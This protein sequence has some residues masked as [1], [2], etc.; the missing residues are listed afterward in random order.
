MDGVRCTLVC[1]K[2]PALITL[3]DAVVEDFIVKV[4]TGRSRS[5]G[6]ALAAGA[7]GAPAGLG[8]RT[9]RQV[10]ARWRVLWS[11]WSGAG[12]T[13]PEAWACTR[14]CALKLSE[15]DFGEPLATELSCAE[16]GNQ[17]RSTHGLSSHDNT[18]DP[19]PSGFRLSVKHIA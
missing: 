14:E 2:A 7:A 12:P 9:F 13:V 19:T 10:G 1:V 3:D 17:Q 8:C 5:R 18:V 15:V 11:W 6:S 4:S 16:A